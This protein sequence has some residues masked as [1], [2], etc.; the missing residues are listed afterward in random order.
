MITYNPVVNNGRF[1]VSGFGKQFTFSAVD[2]ASAKYKFIRKFELI[3]SSG[4]LK[5]LTINVIRPTKRAN[6]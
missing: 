4:T 2:E 5:A 3:Y 1:Q 6:G